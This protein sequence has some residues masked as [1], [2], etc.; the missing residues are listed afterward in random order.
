[1]IQTG[2][3]VKTLDGKIQGIVKETDGYFAAIEMQG[4]TRL[5]IVPLF[6][7]VKV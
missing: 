2:D 6:D 7:L 3:R 1:M 4:R 5:Q